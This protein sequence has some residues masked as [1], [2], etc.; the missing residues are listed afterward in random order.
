MK[1]IRK[2]LTISLCAFLLLGLPVTL[3]APN[4]M[5]TAVNDQLLALSA[6]TIPTRKSG[7]LYVPYSVFTGALGLH[8]SYNTQQ[9]TLLLYNL[10]NSLSFSLTDGYVSDQA[11]N[12]YATPAYSI[13]GT[14]YVPIK[15]ICG[16]FGFSFSTISGMYPV[17]RITS[18]DSTLSDHAFLTANESTIAHAVAAYTGDSGSTAPSTQPSVSG[19]PAIPL[20]VLPQPVEAQLKPSA[21]YLAFIGAPSDATPTILEMLSSYQ[22]KATFFLAADAIPS[23]DEILRRILGEGHAF[24]LS[25]TADKTTAAPETLIA[26]LDTANRQLA[27]ACGVETRLVCV[28]NGASALSQA[29]HTALTQAGY[30]VWAT[31]LDGRDDSLSAYR[32]A[33]RVLTAFHASSDPV[34]LHIRHTANSPSALTYI[35]Q[36]AHD[37]KIPLRQIRL[38]DTPL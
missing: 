6:S 31:T 12:S 4:I 13:N 5:L 8:G 24:G 11:G 2:I 37:A 35:L 29:Q 23:E 27:R 34:V 9:K 19:V 38:S 21:V 28:I 3:A 25:F 33:Q 17:V 30:R 36:Y 14:V 20:P 1:F 10:D 15:L 7:E 26:L 18:G 22:N 16:S 32:S